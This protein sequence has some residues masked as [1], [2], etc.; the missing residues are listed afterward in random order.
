METFKV[1][2]FVYHKLPSNDIVVQNQ[3]GIIKVT[4]QNLNTLIE[5]ID[6]NRIS[7][8]SYEEIEKYMGNNAEASISF[9]KNYGV[10]E[11][12]RTKVNFDVQRIQFITNNEKLETKF[13]E[14]LNDLVNEV[15][16]EMI[17][18]NNL[19]EDFNDNDLIVVFLNPYDKNLAKKIFN[20]VKENNEC[21]LLMTYMYNSNYYIDNFYS[22]KWKNPCHFCHM[23]FIE[24]Q[25]RIA[26]NSDLSYQALIDIL[27]HE[28]NKFAVES[29]LTTVS[30][31]DILSLL[32]RKLDKFIFRTKGNVLFHNESIEDMNSTTMLNTLNN[33]LSND[34]SIHW[35]MC[36]CYE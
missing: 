11:N 29:I 3:E 25:L 10:I 1:K 34:I 2:N 5:H 31:I 19:T 33:S 16:I 23:G 12:S 7:K 6:N 22:S 26:N 13:K 8:I 15:G 21:L 4:N 9:L 24:S 14:I 32:L 17:S 28:D 27:Y 18:N 36:D 35:E 20:R 30:L